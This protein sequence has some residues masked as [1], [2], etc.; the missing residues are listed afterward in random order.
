MLVAA[1]EEERP[2]RRS[3]SPPEALGAADVV[4]LR[5]PVGFFSPPPRRVERLVR[6]LAP[7]PDAR[8]SLMV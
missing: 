7:V 3:S 8:L 6:P 5:S 2:P 4:G 1:M